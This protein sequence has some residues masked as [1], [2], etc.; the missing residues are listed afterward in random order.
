ML[1][2]FGSLGFIALKRHHNQGNSYKGQYLIGAG[3]QFQRFRPLSSWQKAWPH[4]GKHGA[5]EGAE[6]STSCSEGEDC[7]LHT[8]WSLSIVGDLQSPPYSD[9]FPPTKPHILTVSLPM[10]QAYSNHHR[11]LQRNYY[12][13]GFQCNANTME[14]EEEITDTE[15]ERQSERKGPRWSLP[16]MVRTLISVFG[17]N[18]NYRYFKYQSQFLPFK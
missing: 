14:C 1:F 4:L 8:G 3:L 6:S 13:L 7:L 15:I 17:D 11:H 12:F 18:I 10:D 16:S 2:Q 5:G 9:T